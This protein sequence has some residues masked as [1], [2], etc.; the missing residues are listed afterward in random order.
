MDEF[1]KDNIIRRKKFCQGVDEINRR[2][3]ENHRPW[4]MEE[5]PYRRAK[6]ELTTTNVIHTR[7]KEHEVK[8][9]LVATK[10]KSR[11]ISLSLIHI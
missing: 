7:I 3:K 5:M 9:D 1:I 8:E 6:K 10:W 4:I 11:M 2:M